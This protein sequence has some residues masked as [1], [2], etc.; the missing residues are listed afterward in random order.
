MTFAPFKEVSGGQLVKVH[1][2]WQILPKCH[3]FEGASVNHEL[4]L[5]SASDRFCVVS[6]LLFLSVGRTPRLPSLCRAPGKCSDGRGEDR[7][8]EGVQGDEPPLQV[9]PG[10]GPLSAHRFPEFTVKALPAA[11]DMTGCSQGPCGVQPT[12]FHPP[13]LPTAHWYIHRRSWKGC[14]H[15]FWSFLSRKIWSGS[16]FICSSEPQM[17]FMASGANCRKGS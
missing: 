3:C 17:L 6:S 5:S 15:G 12:L 10:A 1:P 13:A 4:P 2:F 14:G 8:S 9:A 11:S 16:E 7:A